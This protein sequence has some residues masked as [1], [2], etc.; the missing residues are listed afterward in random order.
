[1]KINMCFG[2]IFVL[3]LS[4]SASFRIKLF[5]Y[6]FY[7]KKQKIKKASHSFAYN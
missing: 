7:K 5:E 2:G 3:T 1:M 6:I 4:K